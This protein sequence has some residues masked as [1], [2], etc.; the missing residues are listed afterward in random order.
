MSPTLSPLKP[1]QPDTMSSV[2]ASVLHFKGPK[3]EP[4]AL[5]VN[6]DNSLE[7]KSFFKFIFSVY[8]LV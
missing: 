6:D 1:D 2:D 8:A 7:K 3:A 4:I 5:I